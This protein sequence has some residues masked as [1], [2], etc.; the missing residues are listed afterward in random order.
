L[1]TA[2]SKQICFYMYVFSSYVY[3]YINLSKYWKSCVKI[4]LWMYLYIVNVFRLFFVTKSR[5]TSLLSTRYLPDTSIIIVIEWLDT[6]NPIWLPTALEPNV[7]DI[8]GD[9]FKYLILFFTFLKILFLQFFI[10]IIFKFFSFF[11]F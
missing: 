10:V 9:K 8:H 7:G 6:R 3:A 5:F 11:E 1:F 4:H 2:I